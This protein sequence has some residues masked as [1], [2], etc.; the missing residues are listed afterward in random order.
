MYSNRPPQDAGSFVLLSILRG[1]AVILTAYFL[2]RLSSE[3]LPD[4]DSYLQ[5][6][7]INEQL[8]G[9]LFW[10]GKFLG[11][12]KDVGFSYEGFRAVVLVLGLVLCVLLVSYCSRD[13]VQKNK[14]SRILIFVLTFVFLFEFFAVRLRAGLSIFFFSLGFIPIIKGYRLR[15]EDGIRSSAIL[16]FFLISFAIHGETFGV[17]LGF[18][19][20]PLLWNYTPTSESHRKYVRNI[21]VCVLVWTILFWKGVSGSTSFRGDH[22]A[23]ELNFV[24][25]FLICLVPVVLWIPYNF[26]YGKM[27]RRPGVKY[28]YSYFFS[29]NY[30]ICSASVMLMYYMGALEKDGE[31]VV[32][33]ITLSSLGAAFCIS[34]SG[35]NFRNV[36]PIYLI[37]VNSLFFITTVFFYQ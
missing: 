9:K 33:V 22:L 17:L 1:A 24:R 12:I 10:F 13:S 27:Y 14:F 8:D 30:V 18:I 7:T 5:L 2:T 6:F 37:S 32:R 35:L 26:L 25:F 36:F 29:L 15:F 16:L 19:F 34:Y 11:A 28:D 21:C 20:L 3:N 31:A 23:S 4:Y